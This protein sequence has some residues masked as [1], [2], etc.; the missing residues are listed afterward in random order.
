M[1]SLT[2][3]PFPPWG[4]GGRGSGWAQIQ[5]EMEASFRHATCG[6]MI[7]GIKLSPRPACL[8]EAGNTQADLPSPWLL[9][10]SSCSCFSAFLTAKCCRESQG[11]G[12]GETHRR[13]EE[14]D[15]QLYWAFVY[16]SLS[17][18]LIKDDSSQKGALD[19]PDSLPLLPG[20]VPKTPP[21]NIHFPQH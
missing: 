17:A 12:V 2:L 21:Q 15:S 1:G 19:S 6:P 3:R 8:A 13:T 7:W 18:W 14:G 4:R 20:F 5:L 9:A 16:M 11:S 10:R